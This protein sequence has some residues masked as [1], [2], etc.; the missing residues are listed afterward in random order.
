MNA[1]LKPCPL[2]GSRPNSFTD[3]KN[4]TKVCCSNLRCTLNDWFIYDDAWNKRPVEDMLL[5]AL[6]ALTAWAEH[7]V[8]YSQ[9]KPPYWDII[10][11]ARTVIAEVEGDN[12]SQVPPEPV[13]SGE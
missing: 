11:N 9:L 3:R 4:N 2:C 10:N 5:E 8:L 1:K 6:K 13:Q 7:N 12:K